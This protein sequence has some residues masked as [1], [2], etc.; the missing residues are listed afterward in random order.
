[1]PTSRL[2]AAKQLRALQMPTRRDSSELHSIELRHRDRTFL[3]VVDPQNQ[4][5]FSSE[6][7]RVV[8]DDGGYIRRSSL[9]IWL[10]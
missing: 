9:R 5:L 7:L 2:Y 4:A 6:L 3:R 8:A 1:M 10:S